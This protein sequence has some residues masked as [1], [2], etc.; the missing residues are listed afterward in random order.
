M[1]KKH[2]KCLFGDMNLPQS[3]TTNRR[4]HTTITKHTILHAHVWIVSF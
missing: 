3:L 2:K 1:W 4:E